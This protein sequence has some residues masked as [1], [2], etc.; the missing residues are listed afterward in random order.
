MGSLVMATPHLSTAPHAT[1]PTNL[2]TLQLYLM[3]QI[4]YSKAQYVYIHIMYNMSHSRL[5]K[6]A[7]YIIIEW[8]LE[9]KPLTFLDSFQS[10]FF[11]ANVQS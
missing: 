3:F 2:F 10:S 4:N 7:F 8:L 6:G 11:L 1:S 5:K 9:L